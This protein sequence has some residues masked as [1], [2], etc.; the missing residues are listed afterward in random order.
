MSGPVPAFAKCGGK[1]PPCRAVV[2][3]GTRPPTIGCTCADSSGDL[4]LGDL[5]AIGGLAAIAAAPIAAYL[6]GRRVRRRRHP[7]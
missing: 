6:A 5:E 3:N 7:V 4:L 2:A 1:P